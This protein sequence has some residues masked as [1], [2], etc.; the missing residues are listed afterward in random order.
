MV[1]V[2]IVVYHGNIFF[3]VAHI[4]MCSEKTIAIIRRT[5]LFKKKRV[6]VLDV[7]SRSRIVIEIR[8]QRDTNTTSTNFCDK[9][10]PI[11]I[12]H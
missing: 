8:K 2:V 7:V 4:F 10:Y 11:V 3:H 6:R 1:I 5:D 9:I 12:L